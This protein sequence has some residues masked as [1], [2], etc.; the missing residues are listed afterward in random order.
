[1]L[2]ISHYTQTPIPGKASQD[3]KGKIKKFHI[4]L[5]YECFS[6]STLCALHECLML[7]EVRR[8]R[9]TPGTGGTV[10]EYH[11]GALQSS[12]Q[13]PKVRMESEEAL[14]SGQHTEDA[15]TREK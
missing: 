4:Y 10:V 13:R 11:I 15:L 8:G 5:F 6:W 9:W 3:I 2:S 14:Q 1:M 12:L 7:T